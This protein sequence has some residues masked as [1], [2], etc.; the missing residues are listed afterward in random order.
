MLDIIKTN[1]KDRETQ[2][3]INKLYEKYNNGFYVN[4]QRDLTKTKE[5]A[6]YIGRYLS[7]SAIAEYIISDYDGKK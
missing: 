3:L 5:E 6:K 2:K 7:R 4:T 1:F